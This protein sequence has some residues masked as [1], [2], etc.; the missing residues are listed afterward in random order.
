MLD[1]MRGMVTSVLSHLEIRRQDPAE[2]LA[3]REREQEL[4]E[5][6]EDPALAQE[7]ESQ[8]PQAAVA[9]GAAAAPVMSR[10]AADTLDPER[11]ETWGRVSRNAPCPCGSGS[12]YKHCHGKVS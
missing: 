5:G 11:P 12:K 1:E 9:Q 4:H 3:P 10:Q 2:S 8:Q 7:R 6:R